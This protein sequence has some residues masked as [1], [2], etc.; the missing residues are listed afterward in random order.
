MSVYI[1]IWLNFVW[2]LQKQFLF[3]YYE[4]EH[5]VHWDFNG[6][7]IERKQCQR[8]PNLSSMNSGKAAINCTKILNLIEQKY[9]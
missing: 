5:K 4:I 2:Q 7:V 1:Y 6:E 3:K 9:A 8:M